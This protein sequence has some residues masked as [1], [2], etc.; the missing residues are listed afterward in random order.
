M[1]YHKTILLIIL[2][3]FIYGCSGDQRPEKAKHVILIGLDGV[4]AEGLQFAR[5]PHINQL[6]REGAMTLK[7]RN[8]MPTDSRP[9]WAALL[10]GSGPEQNGVLDNSW[11][12]DHPVVKPQVTD[13][14]G[15]FPSVFY[16][17]RN[18]MPDAKIA[19][20]TVSRGFGRSFNTSYM[21]TVAYFSEPN[22]S[23]PGAIPYII[24]EKPEFAFLYLVDT[25]HEGHTYGW[26]S[27]E[28][29]AAIERADA[30]IGELTQAL[31]ENGMYDETYIMVVT[32]HGGLGKGHGG[33]SEQEMMVP[34]II[35][36]PGTV[37]NQLITQPMNTFDTSPTITYLFHLEQPWV[38]IGKPVRAA[39][40][41]DP[42][43]KAMPKKS[44][45]AAP[46]IQ[47]SGGLY[48]K[49][50][51]H[52][53][54]TSDGSDADI[55]YTLDGTEPTLQSA[56]YSE[57]LELSESAVLKARTFSNGEGGPVK[58]A[59]FRILS[60]TKGHGITYT[61]Y[62]GTWMS[63]PYFDKLRSRGKG[64]VYE[65]DVKPVEKR[66]DHFGVVFESYLLVEA[67]GEYTFYI[68]SDDGSKLYINNKEIIDNDG[69]HS[70]LT[71]A[72][73]I[74]LNSGKHPIKVE[75]FDDYMGEHLTL[76]YEGPGVPYQV[77]PADKLFL[78]K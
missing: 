48:I 18:Q 26:E 17:L 59:S 20:F 43:A 6:I 9:N 12:Q 16:A 56:G 5:T 22:T 67:E 11:R 21:D 58:E 31:K 37:K 38:W 54:L 34:W 15:F 73:S 71:K 72:G 36:G 74:E 33:T 7:A 24:S 66:E 32:D 41:A 46:R 19:V 60:N 27:D 65:F 49:E 1:R 68:R 8:V 63:V 69:S 51:A 10:T 50:N 23:I 55:R 45:T 44:Y 2:V 40:A 77:V 47:P 57:P 61:Y 35:K 29:L 25:D 14:D 13:E 28:Y 75:Y 70:A 62:E 3:L 4:S 53:E 42:Q 52:V 64:V 76:F 78:T 39:F 30:N